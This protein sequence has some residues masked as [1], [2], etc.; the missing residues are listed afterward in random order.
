MG[1]FYFTPQ[2]NKTYKAELTYANG[3][4]DTINLP[5][6]T[7]NGISLAV[8]NDSIPK[9]VVTIKAGQSYFRMN[10]GKSLTLVVYNS[11]TVSTLNCT[12]DSVIVKLDVLKR[13][14]HS[15]HAIVTLFSAQGEPLCERMFFVQNY[16]Y[17]S[18]NVN[19]DKAIYKKKD[20]VNI[21]LNVKTRADDPSSG[22]FSVSVIDES[23][24]VVNENEERTIM[25]DLLLTSDLKG[26]IEQPNYYFNNPGT[27]TQGDLDLVM[28]THGY[29]HFEWKKVLDS[30]RRNPIFNLEKAIGIE[31]LVTNLAGKPVANGTVN[32]IT[33]NN[34]VLAT[35]ATDVK[36]LFHFDNFVF[37]DTAHFVLSAV[38]DK[39]RNS[40]RIT[41]FNDQRNA[42]ALLP[43]RQLSGS[44]INDSVMATY[45]RNAKLRQR[46]VANYLKGT[47]IILKQV[48]IKSK[49]PDDQYRTQ[50][51]AGAGGA[52]QVLH[53]EEL[54][55][56]P[57]TTKLY[58]L[59]GVFFDGATLYLTI[60]N[61]ATGKNYAKRM[62]VIVD[63][64]EHADYKYLQANEVET[65]EVLRNASASIYGME[66]AGGVLII[67]TK[68]N[69]GLEA[70]DIT[71][72]GVL[73]ITVPG[74][75]KAREFYSPKYDHPNDTRKYPDRRSTVYWKPE[76]ITDND[77]NA[78]FDYYNAD[79]RGNYKV[80][81]EG[82]DENGSLG[83]LVYRYK[84]E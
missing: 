23:K 28:L 45:V 72:T 76:V 83:R 9:A 38:N 17:L 19:S 60:N 84:V 8:N 73:P 63:G 14:L 46:D 24:V 27:K 33:A 44:P 1:C 41:A 78:S 58:G 13:H 6:A 7:A 5:P 69:R 26:Y 4:H 31:G 35:S 59:R 55:Y 42:P 74:F 53:S 80:T 71:S 11:G 54:G 29:R 65:V 3:L 47:G 70:K 51:F 12:L 30:K 50:S 82:I 15:G 79:G 64:L 81:I 22:H 43:Y 20:K 32:L 56:G 62:L 21:K 66:G 25:T 68:T 36:G 39:N 75:Y 52:D 37:T 34:G 10:K 67:T 61:N 18:L 16:D 77:G 2:E 40:T 49:K 48:N 57:L